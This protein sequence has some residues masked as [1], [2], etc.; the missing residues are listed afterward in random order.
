MTQTAPEPLRY[1]LFPGRHHLLTRFQATYLQDLLGGRVAD[2]AGQALEMAPGAEVVWAVTSANHSNTR[3]NPISFHRR[4]AAIERLSMSEGIPSLVVGVFDTVPTDK[5]ASTTIK[6]METGTNGYV[7]LSPQN[8]VVACST[9]EIIAQYE[10]LGYRVAPVELGH[11]EEPVRPWDVL[12]LLVAGEAAWEDL[13]HPATVDVYSRYRLDQHVQVVC[14][15]P[16]ASSEGSLTPTRQYRT[17]IE[18]FERDALRK[19]EPVR[20]FVQP[21][22]I[23]DIGCATGAMLELFAKD[24]GLHESDLY[25]I[26]ISRHLFEECLHKKAQGAFANPNTFF[27][28]RNVM[29]GPIF[30]ERTVDTTLTFA[31]TH[32]IISYGGGIPSLETFAS[33]LFDHTV[34]GG[35]WINSDVCGPRD[36]DKEVVLELE[37]TS[38]DNSPTPRTD[39]E[40]LTNSE[41]STH[42]EGLSTW[43]RFFQ[44]AHDFSRLNG[45]T[46]TFEVTGANTVRLPLW[47]A[48]EYLETKDYTDNWLSECHETFTVLNEDSWGELV[49]SVGFE[50]DPASHAW[51]NEWMVENRFQGVARL[52]DAQTGTVL[53]WPDTHIQ[54]IARRPHNS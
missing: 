41:V 50:V 14:N 5:F 10:A 52:L 35:V 23:V 42:L 53:P 44:F 27:Y 36:G 28:M 40:S 33:T 8:T 6:N 22:R 20:P 45:R 24:P 1:V 32:E 29:A 4:E 21:G 34:P 51:V 17:Y 49:R 31:L 19:L 39:L 16:L 46:I 9:P 26:E 38:G 3:R 25:G 2:M 54:L 47:A 18:S 7:H 48:M 13:A 12:E 11:P 37:N 15:D 30:P 43:G